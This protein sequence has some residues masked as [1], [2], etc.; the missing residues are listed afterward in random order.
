MVIGL[1]L[2]SIFIMEIL[3]EEIGNY[4]KCTESFEKHKAELHLMKV[5]KKFEEIRNRTA[6]FNNSATAAIYL[7]QM[8]DIQKLEALC[9]LPLIPPRQNLNPLKI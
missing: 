9:T 6:S 2:F 5:Q 8:E 4:V 3:L 7:E 1:L